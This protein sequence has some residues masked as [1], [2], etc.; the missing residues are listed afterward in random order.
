MTALEGK[1]L[2][3]HGRTIA[4]RYARRIGPELAEELRAEAVLRA[5]GSPP[6]DGR[7]EP[8][9]EQIYRNLFVD[10]WRRRQ[11][12]TQDLAALPQPDS[13]G[14]PEEQL[15]FHER[16]RVVRL[17][18]NQL[19][20]QTRRALLSRFYSELD[21]DI[22][23]TRLGVATV[24]IRTRI[25]RGLA[26]LR[27]RLAALR[28]LCPPI[29]GK[30]GT[31]AMAVGLAPVMV[32]ALIVTGSSTP[33]PTPH[34]ETAYIARHQP[35]AHSRARVR[36]ESAVEETI[37]DRA[38]VPASSR[39]RERRAQ[40]RKVTAPSPVPPRIATFFDLADEEPIVVE[41]LHPEVIDV[42]AEPERPTSSCM[43]AAPPSFLTQIDESIEELM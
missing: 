5:L 34:E 22:A 16:R 3:D 27:V 17:S 21:D 9:L 30:V 19:P 6:P 28:G 29:M 11:V 2:L 39:T 14:T 15:L 4:K 42:F 38:I 37:H 10:R 13:D 24:T 1:T 7:M 36:T 31:Q 32:A 23:A 12:R 33:M 8:W 25:H 40:Q 41:V 35:R 26:N 18:L 43:V 20:R